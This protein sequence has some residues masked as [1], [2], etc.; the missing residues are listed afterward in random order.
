MACT[1]TRTV[2]VRNLKCP[3]PFQVAK[4]EAMQ[5]SVGDYFTLRIGVLPTPLLEY[6]EQHA[7][8]YEVTE[9]EQSEYLIRITACDDVLS[10]E[11]AVVAPPMFHQPV[12][13]T[14]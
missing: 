2:D 14:P 8:R 10:L 11:S 1:P 5:L 7:F 9:T 3:E 6:L 12:T 13:A 4:R